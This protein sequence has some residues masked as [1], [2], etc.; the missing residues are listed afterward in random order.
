MAENRELADNRVPPALVW[1]VIAV[2]VAP[3]LLN[4]AGVH[5]GTADDTVSVTA[6]GLR[7]LGEHA[8]VDLLH[9]ALRGSF[10]H[11]VLEWTAF[12]TAAFTAVLSFTRARIERDP[13]TPIVGLALFWAGC[14]DAFHTIATDR[15]VRAAADNQSLVP[16]TWV[17]SRLFNATILLLG[18]GVVLLRWQRLRQRSRPLV[19][20]MACAGFG[21]T[22]VAAI[23][24]C[25]TSEH[26][27]ATTN[28][29]AFIKRPWDVA[30]L[31]LYAIAGGVVFPLFHRRQ[32]SQFS[33]SLWLST[34]PQIVTQLHMAFG[35]SAIYDNHFNIAHFLKIVA[36]LVPFLG[37][38]LD[39][40]RAYRQVTE[41]NQELAALNDLS[42]DI[43]TVL[44]VNRLFEKI[45]DLSR[46][47][48]QAEAATLMLLD[49]PNRT[50]RMHVIRGVA[51]GALSDAT[52]PLGKGISGTVAETGEPALIP[53][54]YADAR[55]DRSFDTRSGFRTRTLLTVPLS[56]QGEI[57]GVLQVV[58]KIDSPAF[59]MRDLHLF[60]SFASLGS[61][62]LQNARM[63]AQLK[64][65]ADELRAA[66][67]QERRLSIEKE[68]MGAYIPKH[69]VDEI[70]RNREQKLALGGKTVHATMLFSD[71]QG[72][73]RL[74]ETLEPQ[75]VVGFLNEYMTAMTTVIE[76]HAGILDKFIGDGIMAIYL[77][78]EKRESS[79]LRAVRSGIEMQCELRALKQRWHEERP[80]VG[81]LQARIGIN[82]GEVVAGNVG[83]M[84]RMEYTVIGDNVNVASRI[85]SNGVGGQVHIS[86]STYLEVRD[87]IPAKRL[88][89]IQVKN[90]TQPVQTYAVQLPDS[91]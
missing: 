77:P 88:D 20:G 66:L 14:L 83:S 63:F 86:E 57:L 46:E 8:R 62:S 90:R 70:S 36:Y 78:D 67:E 72:F 55:F 68:K 11:T 50:L 52:V 19:I 26:L 10:V 5:F 4:L 69:V 45:V 24:L 75:R 29:D 43:I 16:F 2:C 48:M 7:N 64:Q 25:L 1:G 87:S 89:P 47:V 33:A 34:L 61:I 27:P 84:T 31:L 38:L 42:R 3:G 37:L 30:P 22:A 60:Q 74:S 82:S 76:R 49:K 6:D 59:D 15:M 73:T 54:A 85:E 71:I 17:L 51:A 44:D 9:R 91:A 32:R 81:H 80:E 53:D 41:A 56:M 13:I 79:A 58:N 40:S 35:S 23:H 18:V 21:I 39:F 12:S 65:L 28:S